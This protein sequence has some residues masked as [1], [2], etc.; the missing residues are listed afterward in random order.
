MNLDPFNSHSD[1]QLWLALEK[2]NLAGVVR[3][4]PGGLSFDVAEGG[5]NFSAGQKQLL[6]LARSEYDDNLYIERE[7]HRDRYYHRALVRRS[8]ILLLDE[9]TSSVDFRTDALIQKT[10]RKEFGDGS[11]TVLT[12]AHRLDT[13]LDADRILVMEAGR[14]GE[15]D[16]PNQLLASPIS[17]F[18]QLLRAERGSLPFQIQR[19]RGRVGGSAF[20]QAPSPGELDL[21]NE[22]VGQPFSESNVGGR[23]GPAAEKTSK[24]SGI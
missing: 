20:V 18:S 19:R 7:Y 4:L 24:S 1:E 14:V 11:C 12:I 3:N 17:L 9:A 22:F 6:C 23:S 16:S 15:Y 2:S 13:I 8:K 10:I 21:S 5:D